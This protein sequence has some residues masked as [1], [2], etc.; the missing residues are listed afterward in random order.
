MQDLHKKSHKRGGKKHSHQ[1]K[2]QTAVYI[3][4]EQYNAMFDREKF[5]KSDT[6]Q[7]AIELEDRENVIDMSEMAKSTKTTDMD[8]ERFSCILSEY[9]KKQRAIKRNYLHVLPY[10]IEEKNKKN[11]FL[12]EAQQP[13]ILLDTSKSKKKVIQFDVEGSKAEI[14]CPPRRFDNALD[15]IALEKAKNDKA[16]FMKMFQEA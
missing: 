2:E 13:K 1:H 11:K 3:T 16:E 10:Y 4:S 7:Q 6:V 14:R 5:A 12:E 9:S 15:P 8:P